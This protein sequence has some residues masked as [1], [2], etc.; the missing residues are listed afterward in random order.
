MRELI[1]ETTLDLIDG[2][3]S[4]EWWTSYTKH[5]KHNKD[6]ELISALSEIKGMMSLRNELVSR[7]DTTQPDIDFTKKFV[8]G[9]SANE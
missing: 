6:A 3:L 9:F 8:K 2:W 4:E 7:I 1:N 5:T